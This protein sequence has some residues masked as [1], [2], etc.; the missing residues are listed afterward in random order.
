MIL[1]TN[2]TGILQQ[3]QW[4][5]CYAYEITDFSY[6]ASETL[7]ESKIDNVT[8]NRHGAKFL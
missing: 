8:E 2:A 1:H 4:Y 6:P 5:V 7:E 3:N